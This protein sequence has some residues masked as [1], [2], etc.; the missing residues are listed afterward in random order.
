M[1]QK[2]CSKKESPTLLKILPQNNNKKLKINSIIYLNKNV[3]K[4]K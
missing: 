1:N 4:N 2:S 3:K